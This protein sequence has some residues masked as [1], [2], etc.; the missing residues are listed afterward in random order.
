MLREAS[1]T[2][3]NIGLLWLGDVAQRHGRN[4]LAARITVLVIPSAWLNDKV[5]GI[6]SLDL[7]RDQNAMAAGHGIPAT[8]SGAPL[9]LRNLK[10][11]FSPVGN[12]SSQRINGG[13]PTLHP[14]IRRK[15][16]SF[17]V[18]HCRGVPVA[19]KYV[20]REVPLRCLK[21]PACGIL[22]ILRVSPERA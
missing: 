13:N 22:V 14:R 11:R 17:L 21:S 15:L 19:I 4:A 16:S 10:C 6:I 7:M 5:A 2:K 1:G 9:G 18:S 12:K 20:W 8:P 3:Q